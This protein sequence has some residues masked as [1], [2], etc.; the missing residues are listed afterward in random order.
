MRT[1]NSVQSTSWPTYMDVRQQARQMRDVAA[2]V[3]D[4]APPRPR[5]NWDRTRSWT[6]GL[7]WSSPVVEEL[8]V[9]GVAM[10]IPTYP[11][12][13]DYAARCR[14]AGRSDP[15]PWCSLD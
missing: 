6:P 4:G 8:L 7:A 13:R 9:W 15:G 11:R 5:A 3:I 2:H 1:D 14:V 10:D 12:G